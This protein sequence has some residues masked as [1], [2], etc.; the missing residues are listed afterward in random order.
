MLNGTSV[1]GKFTAQVVHRA[2]SP[3]KP[4]RVRLVLI[5]ALVIMILSPGLVLWLPRLFGY[6][7]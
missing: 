4:P 1:G 2:K 7:G 5:L 6:A 3:W